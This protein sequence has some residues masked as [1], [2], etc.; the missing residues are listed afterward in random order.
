MIDRRASKSEPASPRARAALVGLVAAT[1][2]ACSSVSLDP[3]PVRV[4]TVPPTGTS[5]PPRTAGAAAP[6]VS[7]PPVAVASPVA[8][9]TPA[10]GAPLAAD[11]PA[12]TE[13]PGVAA[14]FPDPA[15]SYRTP[16]LA[17][18]RTTF[19]SNAELQSLLRSLVRE[20]PPSANATT[21][22]LV[23]VGN[24]QA[25]VP[26]DALYFTRDAGV[27]V[28][29][30]S[31]RPTV[32]LVGQQ[33]GDEPAGSEALLVIAQE[34]AQGKLQ[35]LLDRINVV[36]LPRANPDGMLASKR[37]SASGID[38]NRD[39][40]LLRTPEAQAIAT[41]AR[42]FDP[43]VVVDLHEYSVLGRFLDKFGAVQRFDVLL[44]YATTANLPEFVGKASEEWF[45]R[46]VLQALK[47]EGLS[48]EW[49]YTT[50][51]DIA[52][53]KISMG[54]VQPD[55]GRNVHGL[56]N[57]VS[58]LIETRGIGL[59]R[60]HLLRRVHSH[61][62]A[63]TSILT[64]TATRSA[65]LL[66]LRQF[67]AADVSAKACQGEMVVEAAA[68][69]SEYN[70]VML[71]PQTGADKKLAVTWDSALELTPVKRRAR[72]CGYWLRA[73]QI[74][75]VLRLRGL[76]VVVHK[77]DDAGAL[78]GETYRETA[79]EM[80]VRS[81][82]RGSIADAGGVLNVKVELVPALIDVPAGS[83]YVGLDQPLANLVAAA[84][85]PD[86]Q[87]SYV[88]NRVVTGVDGEARV[89]LRPEVRMT[90]VP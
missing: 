76:G 42:D 37:V 89:L 65:D 36:L 27:A 56:R 32:L 77:L 72:P 16:G 66:K 88:T 67:V 57:A 5:S 26:L 46:P 50:S 3:A 79:R 78:R 9:P 41:L 52:D 6:T 14:R 63:I 25:G 75:A 87:N 62:V 23:Q 84:L 34:L 81:D 74:D 60:A 68:T 29:G 22:R 1:L 80:G 64:S 2:V 40:L 30:R 73:D 55:T 82:V 28:P 58:V 48:V 45:R 35:T 54:G 83:Y 44:Q 59:G 33:H 7:A 61:V 39:H 69:P 70:L 85:E 31:A 51:T 90:P 20:E 49:Y 13:S 21:I 19:T 15:V 53:K 17:A 86:T 10:S 4:V 38:I 43:A 47:T 8:P 18:G 12:L 11:E 71:D 24:S